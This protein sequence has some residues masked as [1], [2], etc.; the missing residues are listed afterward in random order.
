MA[1]A[2][3]YLK[4]L[5]KTEKDSID[6]CNRATGISEILGNCEEA[7]LH[8]LSGNAAKKYLDDYAK[9]YLFQ[10]LSYLIMDKLEQAKYLWKRLPN[11]CKADP[12]TANVWKIGQSMWNDEHKKVYEIINTIK[13]SKLYLPFIKKIE[14]NYRIK[15]IKLINKAYTS[16]TINEVINN[17]LGFNNINE[18]KI[19]YN[20]NNTIKNNWEI[21]ND[22]YININ[23]N[24]D[25]NSDLTNESVLLNKFTQYVCF[26]ESQQKLAID[27]NAA[28]LKANN[29]NNNKNNNSNKK[30][31]K[32]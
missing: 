30:P 8:F 15:M 32:Y 24:N 4:L 3:E 19:Y 16:I 21:I 18:F 9:S 27:S 20:N 1:G 10:L 17:Y 22:K 12:L 26:M 7:E 25:N 6:V 5:P 13:P 11:D 23:N 29:D 2:N 14:K 31:I 28:A